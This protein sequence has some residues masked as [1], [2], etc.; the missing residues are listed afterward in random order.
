GWADRAAVWLL[1]GLTL[2]LG[3]SIL[4]LPFINS[5][6]L[7]EIPLLALFQVPKLDLAGWFRVDV[8][9]PIIRVLGMSAGSFSPD[10]IAARPYGLL[11]AYLLPALA[12]VGALWVCRATARPTRRWLLV[13]LAVG[14]LDYCFVMLFAAGPPGLTIH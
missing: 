3:A 6:W 9:M 12:V 2:Y 5:L 11:L 1:K 7:G 8:I 10:Y 4:T 14:V 13:L